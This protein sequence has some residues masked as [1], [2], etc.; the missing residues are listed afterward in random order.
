[1]AIAQRGQQSINPIVEAL[2]GHVEDDNWREVSL[3]TIGY[4]GIIQQR[5]EAAGTAL[6]RLIQQ[7]PGELGQAV[8][9]A[10]EAVVDAWPG[11]V[12]PACKNEV[13]RALQNTMKNDAQVK[14]LLRARAGDALARL[15]DP[16]REVMTIEDMQFCFV[17]AGP[18]WM[19]DEDKTNMKPN[20][21]LDYDYWISRYP[22]TNAQFA[23]FVQAGGYQEARYWQEAKAENFWQDGKFKGRYDDN[24]RTQPYDFGAPFNLPNHPV[25]GITWYEALAFSRW[26]NEV[27]Q[28]KNW[29]E[30]KIS[31]QLPSEVEWEKAAR[32]GEE[33]PQSHIITAISEIRTNARLSAQ[34]GPNEQRKRNDKLQRQ[35][36][37]DDN[38]DP[39]RANYADTGINATSAV[40]CFP[41]GASPYGCE[42]MSGNVWEWTRSLWENYPY[43]T[44][45]KE[46]AKRENLEAPRDKGRVWRGGAF[47]SDDRFVRCAAR[48]RNYPYNWDYRLGFRVAVLPLL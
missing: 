24:F 11:G 15:G 44:D 23:E 38:P 22:I 21:A 31:V 43:P 12:T 16:R 7:A 35:Y 20:S 47:Y 18:F 41:G 5:D 39:N 48:D 33:I 3:L 10:G 30:A 27:C 13:A 28:N 25:V 1:M 14:A 8:V 4:L 34:A 37:W 45:A 36:P 32:G 29:R 46:R 17:P 19:G 26:L 9:L 6:Q 2:A 42:E 40:G